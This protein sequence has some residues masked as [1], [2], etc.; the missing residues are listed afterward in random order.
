MR[1]KGCIGRSPPMDV[2]LF[3][4]SDSRYGLWLSCVREV[5]R[6]VHPLA[7]PGAPAVVLGVIRV[8]GEVVPVFDVRSRFGKPSRE[9][10]PSDH[11]IIAKVRK[12]LVAL[13]VDAVSGIIDVT[14]AQLDSGR[15]L[16]RDLE[17]LAGIAAVE[18]GLVLIHELGS[19]LSQAEEAQVDAAL[20][21]VAQ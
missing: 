17:N 10:L 19:F 14:D 4:L 9:A 5:A 8:R 2:L 1:P 13:A 12:R 11:L 3:E 16:P 15:H 7:L 21:D 18:G 20:R 6:A